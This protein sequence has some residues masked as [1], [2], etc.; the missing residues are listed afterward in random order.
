MYEEILIERVFYWKGQAKTRATRADRNDR[1]MQVQA[2]IIICTGTYYM[3][4]CCF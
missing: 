4:P 2:F 3:V 1:S